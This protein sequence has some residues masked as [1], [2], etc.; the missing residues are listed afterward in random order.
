MVRGIT[1]VA[2]FAVL[3][4]CVA[5]SGDGGIL[6]LKNVH[7]TAECT[8]TASLTELSS[9]SGSLELLFPTSYLFIAQLKSRITALDGQE[10]QRTIIAQGAN[11]DITFPNTTVLTADDVAGFKARGLTHFKQLFSAPVFPNGGISDVGFNLIPADLVA[12]IAMEKGIVPGVVP[13]MPVQVQVEAVAT[14]TVFG[15]MS[16]ESIEG[17][18]F[19]YPVTIGTNVTA[20]N[21]GAC[22]DLSSTFVPSTG[23]V[24]NSLQDGR[25]DCCTRPVMNQD[26]SITTFLVCPVPSKT[27]V[28]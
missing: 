11:V 10:D 25:L 9:S 14:F 22:S 20:V 12:A 1:P 15:D 21:N 13:A 3:T 8:T 17:Q 18:P 23:Y 6:V 26:G 5:D 7:P 27:A 24:C 2:L 4:G 19:T 28:R 16:G